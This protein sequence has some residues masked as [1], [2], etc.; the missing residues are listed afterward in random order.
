MVA[1]NFVGDLQ[2]CLDSAFEWGS[3]LSIE[4]IVVNNGST[5]DT[6]SWLEKRSKNDRRIS[7]THT[8]HILGEASARNIILRQSRGRTIIM[9]ET[10]AEIT[11]NIFDPI[12]SI[13]EDKSIGV[14]GPF[15][16]KSSD[17]RHF[18]DSK[19]SAGD[20]DAM[21]AYFFAFRRARLSNVGFMRESFRFYR[22]LDIDYSFHFK[23][24][25]YRIFADPKLPVEIHEHRAWNELS[26][27]ERDDLSQ[28]NFAR[29][30][31][32]WG[33]RLDLIVSNSPTHQQD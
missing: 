15:G 20:M 33:S 9:L 10:C 27:T 28:K 22:N 5:D 29:F 1:R 17:L 14:T 31:N 2:R 8:D 3:N 11:G 26:E 23:D 25:G 18:H 21:Q 6:P 7:V 30:L 24:K 32:K 13:L 16:L 19:G 4:A 12:D